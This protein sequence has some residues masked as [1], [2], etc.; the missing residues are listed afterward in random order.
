ME[1]KAYQSRM[2]MG[3]GG[4]MKMTERREGHREEEMLTSKSY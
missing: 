4:L 1:P 3:G 2:D